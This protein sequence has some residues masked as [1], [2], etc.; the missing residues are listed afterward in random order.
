[1][2]VYEYRAVREGCEYCRHRF[3]AIQ[4]MEE[5]AMRNCPECGASLRRLFSRPCLSVVE[6]ISEQERM[7][8]YAPEE[9]DRLGLTDGFAEDEIYDTGQGS[10]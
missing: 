7:V 6:H 10:V 2:P 8:K 9:A 4:R 3:E 1:M 5:E